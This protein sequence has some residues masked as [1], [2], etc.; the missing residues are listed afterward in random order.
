MAYQEKNSAVVDATDERTLLQR[1]IEV[2]E[3]RAKQ[4]AEGRKQAPSS[5][6]FGRILAE[7]MEAMVKRLVPESF[8]DP[9]AKRVQGL[10]GQYKP[11]A[12]V[13]CAW[14]LE[15]DHRKMVNNGYIPV[16]EDDGT[17]AR[18]NEMLLY[19]RDIE[20]VRQ[21]IASDAAISDQRFRSSGAVVGQE[22]DDAQR[23]GGEVT[24][25]TLTVTQKN[26]RGGK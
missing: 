18:H 10:E 17:H 5:I 3:R 7:P 14:G 9:K 1:D 21:E 13:H 24:E 23:Q 19:K 26:I 25:N 12:K 6:R 4:I 15:K 8:S 20:L 11:G 16:L 22:L 2:A